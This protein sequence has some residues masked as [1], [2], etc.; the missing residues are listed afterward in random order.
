M[1]FFHRVIG[2]LITKISILE[3]ISPLLTT[4]LDGPSW[5]LPSLER[6]V[7]LQGANRK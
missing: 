5:L 6:L 7:V 1:A 2:I 4:V 3:G